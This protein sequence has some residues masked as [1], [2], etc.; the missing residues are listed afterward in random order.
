MKYYTVHKN[1]MTRQAHTSHCIEAARPICEP[2]I[3]I[4]RCK[5]NRQALF[6]AQ[7]RRAFNSFSIGSFV[8]I[9]QLKAPF[10]FFRKKTFV[11]RVLVAREKLGRPRWGNIIKM[12]AWVDFR[13]SSRWSS[14]CSC[15][16]KREIKSKK[17]LV[18][19]DKNSFYV[20]IV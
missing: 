10:L 13:S 4:F 16:C 18:L 19:L 17:K 2:P 6:P 9:A 5:K 20:R 1:F 8:E 3:D 7:K 15:V 14:L 11:T 12:D